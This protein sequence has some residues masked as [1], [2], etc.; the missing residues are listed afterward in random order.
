MA[1]HAAR[2]PRAD[3]AH[4]RIIKDE[5]AQNIIIVGSGVQLNNDVVTGIIEG[6]TDHERIFRHTL[7]CTQNQMVLVD[8][9]SS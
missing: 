6:A 9:H 4:G 8:S 2:G 5:G 7:P 1:R 3:Q